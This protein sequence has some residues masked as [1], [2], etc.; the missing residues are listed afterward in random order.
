MELRTQSWGDDLRLPTV[1]SAAHTEPLF[2]HADGLRKPPVPFQSKHLP[3]LKRNT[4]YALQRPSCRS[5]MGILYVWPEAKS[6]VYISGDRQRPRIA[7]LRLRLDPQFLAPGMGATVFQA[8]LS[9][10]GRR[11]WI[12]DVLV[13][14]GR[15]VWT[16]EPFSARWSL[17]TQW[18]AHSC[19]ADSKLIGGI[20][21]ELAPWT[22]L[23]AVRPVGIWEFQSDQAGQRRLYWNAAPGRTE[24]SDKQK[25]SISIPIK[26]TPE[27]LETHN[28]PLVAIAT[29]DS[30]PDQW[31]LATAD[32]VKLGRALIRKM[33]VSTELRAFPEKTALVEVEWCLA[34][35]KWEIKSI[36]VGGV[37]THSRFFEPPK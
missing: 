14:K 26:Q 34:F 15:D 3:A 23:D 29:R 36:C 8:T 2:E 31:N 18:L 32:G 7:L 1:I 35:S 19:V 13:W 11:L 30:G 9:A 27:N 33:A 21:V 25:S 22:C 17:A 20:S 6:C 37:A 28:G 12:E 24:N 10:A 16:N 4:W 5:R